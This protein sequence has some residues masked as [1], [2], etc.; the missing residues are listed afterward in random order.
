[1]DR[2]EASEAT[3]P[4]HARTP[5][6]LHA[7]LGRGAREAPT[8]PSEASHH[9]ATR[10]LRLSQPGQTKSSFFCL[11]PQRTHAFRTAVSGRDA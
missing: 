11:E 9:N 7:R 3:Q 1:M 6:R 4:A 8:R 2:L 5:P 10:S